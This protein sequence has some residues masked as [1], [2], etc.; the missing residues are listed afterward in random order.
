MTCVVE[1]ALYIC[2]SPRCF[3]RALVARHAHWALWFHRRSMTD[4]GF[5]RSQRDGKG[6]ETSS[7]PRS[8]NGPARDQVRYTHVGSEEQDARRR[9]SSW[10]F[11][12]GLQ[13]LPIGLI[14]FVSSG[15]SGEVP[16]FLMD[17]TLHRGSPFVRHRD[18]VCA[19]AR[20]NSEQSWAL[21][22][23]R[24]IFY[25]AIAIAV[26]YA[27]VRFWPAYYWPH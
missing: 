8:G 13:H 27:I 21:G 5:R 22:M 17:A 19:M 16:S 24:F 15:P 4:V 11:A 6:T 18:K 10:S 2:F 3:E 12:R 14:P 20:E 1:P 7:L 25:V 23:V 26:G 9:R